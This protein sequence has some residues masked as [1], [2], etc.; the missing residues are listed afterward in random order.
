MALFLSGKHD[1]GSVLQV[2]LSMTNEIPSVMQ[3]LGEMTSYMPITGGHMMYAG[4]FVDP[5]LAFAVNWAY[6]V[7]WLL[8]TPAE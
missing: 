2:E 3:G 7:Q 5:A 8:V 6:A 1:R 4:R